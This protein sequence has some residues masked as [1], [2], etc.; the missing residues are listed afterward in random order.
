MLR[1]AYRGPSHVLPRRVR[2]RG[3]SVAR[4]IGN[5]SGNGRATPPAAVP[6]RAF[7][8][9]EQRGAVKVGTL[10]G[11][12]GATSYVA[13]PAH[14]LTTSLPARVDGDRLRR[15]PRHH[16]DQTG[17]TCCVRPLQQHIRLGVWGGKNPTSQASHELVVWEQL[18]AQSPHIDYSSRTPRL[19]LVHH[20]ERGIRFCNRSWDSIPAEDEDAPDCALPLCLALRC[21]SSWSS[22]AT[23]RQQCQGDGGNPIDRRA[24]SFG[25][26]WL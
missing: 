23:R 16:D 15:K 21:L 26:R 5:G 14:R 25:P 6:G 9:T 2:C 13:R 24:S 10:S 4:P 12:G 7:G 20:T 22:S 3:A 18:V 17:P 1:R 19:Q 11:R 8:G